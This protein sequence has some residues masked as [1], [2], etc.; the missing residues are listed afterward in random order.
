MIDHFKVLFSITAFFRSGCNRL[1]NLR[2]GYD[3]TPFQEFTLDKFFDEWN[4]QFLGIS[5][6][7][8]LITSVT[9][10]GRSYHRFGRLKAIKK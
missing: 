10:S 3:I 2:L 9:I 6:L 1:I 5:N 7:F 8:K 4:G